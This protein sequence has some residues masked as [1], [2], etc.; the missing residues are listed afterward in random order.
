MD[1]ALFHEL[2]PDVQNII[3][4]DDEPVDNIFSEKQQR[5]LTETL[6]NSWDG[7][8]RTF[9]AAANVGVFRSVYE[10]PLVPD[11]FISMDVKPRA[12]WQ[13]K[14]R[15]TY[16]CWEFGKPPEVVIEIVS[17]RKGGELSR[18]LQDYARL[19]A[20]Y[21][22][23]FDP[24]GE[25]AKDLQG[26][27]LR[28]YRLHHGSYTPM[29]DFWLEDIG[30]GLRLWEGE[31]EGWHATWIRWCDARGNLL[32]TGKERADIEEQRAEK[33]YKRAEKAESIMRRMAEKMR[34]A[35]LNP[36]DI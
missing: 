16:F 8:G 12:E 20:W 24:A 19:Q 25:L 22:V 5:L 30:L 14:D 4:E 23:V 28:L 3:T 36:D 18:K 17:N 35:G 32:P 15:K 11:A 26:E 10:P 34:A 9:F 7:G 6:H 2:L 21:Y 29:S 1:P 33:E 13:N 31:Y 27:S